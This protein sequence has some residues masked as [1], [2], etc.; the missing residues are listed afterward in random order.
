[1]QNHKTFISANERKTD[2]DSNQEWELVILH[3]FLSNYTNYLSNMNFSTYNQNNRDPDLL[4]SGKVPDP[5]QWYTERE[6]Y[7]IIDIFF[8]FLAE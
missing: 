1:M 2:Q 4:V 3:Y 8:F 7:Y 6:K 5:Q